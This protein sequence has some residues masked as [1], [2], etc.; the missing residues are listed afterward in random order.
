MAIRKLARDLMPGDL[1]TTGTGKEVIV[2]AEPTWRADHRSPQ[3][4]SI[5][6]VELRISRMSLRIQF[7]A[8][9]IVEVF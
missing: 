3:G 8:D 2:V 1:I 9:Q 5:V 7:R 6:P 4:T